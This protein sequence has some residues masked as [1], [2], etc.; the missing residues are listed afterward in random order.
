MSKQVVFTVGNSLRGDDGA[1]SLLA[2]LL[3]AEPAPDWVVIDGG[4]APE[5]RR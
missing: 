3:Q 4:S 2:E 1:G 5:N